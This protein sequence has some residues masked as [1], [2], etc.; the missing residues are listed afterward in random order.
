MRE[1]DINTSIFVSSIIIIEEGLLFVIAVDFIFYSTTVIC[2]VYGLEKVQYGPIEPTENA[3]RL[4]QLPNVEAI[5]WELR[6]GW[7]YL[8]VWEFTNPLHPEPQDP[9]RPKWGISSINFM[10]DD[11]QG[12]YERLQ[13]KV[14]FNSA[15]V[16]VGDGWL[17]M[18][19]DLYGYMI[20]LWQLDQND[21]Q[22]FE[23]AVYPHG[24]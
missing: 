6:S 14:A 18:G 19:R 17:A 4:C 8:E 13:D 11:C 3:E 21:P 2:S 10:T 15:P 24:K 7:C 9:K 12:E 5:G 1:N 16:R 20:E 23:P 22:P